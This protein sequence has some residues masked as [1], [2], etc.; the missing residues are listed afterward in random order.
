MVV[1][2]CIYRARM[3]YVG[4]GGLMTQYW[5]PSA[6]HNALAITFAAKRW[7]WH[8]RPQPAGWV[9]WADDYSRPLGVYP[10]LM[11]AKMERRDCGESTDT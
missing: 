4:T 3:G 10:T 6:Y 8:G 5:Y 2:V 11:A 7:L 9:V 1:G